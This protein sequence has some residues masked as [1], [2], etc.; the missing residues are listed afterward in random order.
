MVTTS[1]ERGSWPTLNT[2]SG[3]SKASSRGT[4]DTRTFRA[5]DICLLPILRERLCIGHFAKLEFNAGFRPTREADG[6]VAGQAFLSDTLQNG[7]G[8]CRWLGQPENFERLLREGDISKEGSSAQQWTVS[9]HGEECDTSCDRCLRDFYNLFYHGLLDWRLALDMTRLAL[10]PSTV[11]D[12]TSSWH[13]QDKPWQSL[14]NGSNAPIPVILE[15]L[16]YRQATEIGGLQ[17][18][19][20]EG[21]NRVSIVRHPLWTDALPRLQPSTI[22]SSPTVALVTSSLSGTSGCIR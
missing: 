6:S 9:L 3:S 5:K 4:S 22:R 18:Y 14:C 15:N 2:S 21:F 7:A 12:L 16:G 10:N 20:R 13:G 11:L 19:W 8:Y 17:V 1:S